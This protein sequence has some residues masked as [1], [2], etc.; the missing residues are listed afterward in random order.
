M[1]V[2]PSSG[3]A[4]MPSTVVTISAWEM[5]LAGGGALAW[6]IVLRRRNPEFLAD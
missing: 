4:V 6:M 3:S 2:N 1:H 5:L